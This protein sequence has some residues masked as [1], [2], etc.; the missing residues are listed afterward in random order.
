MGMLAEGVRNTIGF[1]IA[2]FWLRIFDSLTTIILNG[3]RLSSRIGTI[4][5]DWGGS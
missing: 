2:L 1:I 5:S 3:E 4:T